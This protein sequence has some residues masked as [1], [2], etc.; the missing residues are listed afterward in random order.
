LK[1][2]FVINPVSGGVDKA[3]WAAA[4]E[5]YFA[6]T[7]HQTRLVYLTGQHDAALIQHEL[8]SWVPDRLVAV[9]GDGTVK[10]AA[11]QLIGTPTPL[12]ILP[13]G[14]ANGMS[15]ELNLPTDRTALLALLAGGT[16]RA[17]DLIRINQQ[18]ACLHLS[19]IGINAHLVKH[20]Q[21]NNWRGKFGYARAIL[22]VLLRRR[23]LRVRIET[24]RQAVRRKAYMVVLANARV[25]G[26]G[27]VIN[28]EGDL[29]D[30]RFEVVILRTLSFFELLKLFWRYRPFDPRHIEI[31]PTT[32]VRIE[33]RRRAYFQVDGEYRGR[34]RAV[35]AHI[36][37]GQ[38]WVVLP[39]D[40]AKKPGT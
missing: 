24:Q 10:L 30:G 40:P 11:E 32:S 34:V 1:L 31:V 8:R 2:L 17:I 21:D 25:Y 22:A 16:V 15:R 6:E 37:P 9:G 20:A 27:A 23:V 29:H 3:D 18:E 12:G 38:L 13:A 33:T 5:A 4:I 36:E 35:E 28:P 19:D 7:V 14:S 26:T 39:A